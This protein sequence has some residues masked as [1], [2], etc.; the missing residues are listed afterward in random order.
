MSWRSEDDCP[1]NRSSLISFHVGLHV[2]VTNKYG[3]PYA[4]TY[5]IAS[6]AYSSMCRGLPVNVDGNMA[7][8]P[9]SFGLTLPS[10]KIVSRKWMYCSERN[11]V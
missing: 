3:R 10:L 2:K 6:C 4:R 8:L 9:N 11:S 1:T 5:V 7:I